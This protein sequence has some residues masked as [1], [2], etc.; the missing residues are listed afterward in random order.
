MIQNDSEDDPGS[1]KKHGENVRNVYQRSRNT[2]AQANRDEQH[3]R[4]NSRIMEAE[5]RISDLEDGMVEIT[6]L[7]T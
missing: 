4:I 1:W 5:E 3:T 2:K 6:A 7:K